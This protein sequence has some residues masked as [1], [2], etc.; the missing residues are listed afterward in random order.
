MAMSQ[1]HSSLR[2]FEGSVHIRADEELPYA[3][4]L[5]A[6]N[7]ESLE[8]LKVEGMS[9]T[10]RYTMNIFAIIQVLNSSFF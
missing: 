5:S 2:V 4:I 1:K 7:K 3:T 10:V 8:E 6:T 9:I